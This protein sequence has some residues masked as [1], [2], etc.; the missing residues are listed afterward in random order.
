MRASTVAVVGLVLLG[1]A[2]SCKTFKRDEQ[3]LPPGGDAQAGP[4]R[5]VVDDGGLVGGGGTGG[6]GGVDGGASQ[7]GTGGAG[8]RVADAGGAHDSAADLAVDG[9]SLP[10][11]D[12]REVGARTCDLLMQ[13]CGVNQGCYPGPNGNGACQPNDFGLPSN[14]PCSEPSMC[15]PGL[16]CSGGNCTA[17]CSTTQANCPGG[18]RCIPLAAYN[19]V[20]ACAP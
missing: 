13:N 1:G 19:G 17:L 6:T 16:T 18:G 15:Q 9:A 4:G 14:S 20:G 2:L 3:N 5:Q 8:G 7:G 10:D 12:Q 11:A